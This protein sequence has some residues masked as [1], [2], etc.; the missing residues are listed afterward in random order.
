MQLVD[1]TMRFMILGIKVGPQRDSFEDLDSTG[2]PFAEVWF[3]IVQ[4][5]RYDQLFDETKRRNVQ[6]GLHFWGFIRDNIWTTI[7]YDD[8]SICAESMTQY[9]HTIDI[10]ARHNCVYV[11]IH[12]TSRSL[13]K[14]D[15]ERQTFTKVSDA[16]AY[17]KAELLFFDYLN[18]LHQYATQRGVLLT[19]ETIPLFQTIGAPTVQ[20]RSHPVDMEELTNA[21][22]LK[23]A[24][25]GY[26]IANDF[27]HTASSVV[28]SERATVIQHVQKL[29]HQMTLQTRLLHLGYVVSPW[30]GTDFHDHL[31]NPTFTSAD[32]VPNRTEMM[33][34]LRPFV[35]RNDV[36]ALCEPPLGTHVKNYELAKKLIEEASQK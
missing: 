21:T 23:A 2:A 27:G 1:G 15:F 12:P 10:A 16:T 31:D 35:L 18:E 33:E 32:A 24:E 34:L 4:H 3:N 26:W 14:I 29:S 9:K 19:I 5:D 20:T 6:L 30:N 17:E 28:S 25:R 13:V 8:E 22:V 36:Y 11:N 7:S